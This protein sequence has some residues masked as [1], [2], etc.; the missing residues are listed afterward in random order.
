MNVRI[1]LLGQF[2]ADYMGIGVITV[3]AH[4]EMLVIKRMMGRESK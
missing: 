1:T 4:A 2:D 3:L